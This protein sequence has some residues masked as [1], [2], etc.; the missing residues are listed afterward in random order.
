MIRS[1]QVVGDEAVHAFF[2]CCVPAILDGWP[3]LPV[4]HVVRQIP[5]DPQHVIERLARERGAKALLGT[6][7]A[8]RG[9]KGKLRCADRLNRPGEIV[10][11][12]LRDGDGR[13]GTLLLPD[14]FLSDGVLPQLLGP[15]GTSLFL[16][17]SAQET[18]LLE[19]AGCATYPL[20]AV[21]WANRRAV[22]EFCKSVPWA[23][24]IL[25]PVNDIG[26]GDFTELP[27]AVALLARLRR[28]SHAN[29]SWA[30]RLKFTFVRLHLSQKRDIA[31]LVRG[32]DGALAGYLLRGPVGK[33]RLKPVRLVLPG[34]ILC[35]GLPPL[36]AWHARSG[37]VEP[38]D[39]LGH[40]EI[41]Q[42]SPARDRP[43]RVRLLGEQVPDLA[44]Q[45]RRAV[46]RDTLMDVTNRG[47][48]TYRLDPDFIASTL[49]VPIPELSRHLW[50]FARGSAS[51]PDC[52][53]SAQWSEYLP[54][55][56]A[57]GHLVDPDGPPQ[58][59]AE[60]ELLLVAPPPM[61]APATIRCAAR[62][63][64]HPDSAVRILWCEDI[65]VIPSPGES[66][67]GPKDVLEP[68]L[69]DGQL[70]AMNERLEQLA[71][72]LAA[73]VHQGGQQSELIALLCLLVHGS[74]LQIRLP[75]GRALGCGQL[76]VCILGESGSRKSSVA[77]ELAKLLGLSALATGDTLTRAGLVF[78]ISG[79][80][81]LPGLLSGN[82]AGMLTLDEIHKVGRS[83]IRAATSARSDGVL[84]VHGR[85]SAELPMRTR[86]LG[87]GNLQRQSARGRE[88]KRSLRLADLAAGIEGAGFLECEDA[89]RFD[90][91]LITS[92]SAAT[93]E[94]GSRAQKLD[95]GKLVEL[96]E[97]YW[98]IGASG[99]DE[100]IWETGAFPAVVAAAKALND[101]FECD[102][103]PIFGSDTADK[104]VRLVAAA[105]RVLPVQNDWRTRITTAHVQ[106]VQ[107]LLT[108]IYT[109]PACGLEEVARRERQAEAKPS[110]EELDRI[111]RAVER[112]IA[113]EELDP[114]LEALAERPRLTT[115]ELGGRIDLGVRSTR[116]RVAVL[117]EAGLLRSCGRGGL[118]ALPLMKHLAEYRR[119]LR[120][121]SKEG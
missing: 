117:R 58:A 67:A 28:W 80:E 26:S 120:A 35:N 76:Q 25:V 13:P 42:L 34:N 70:E 21:E 12:V 53:V 44:T 10:A 75:T 16:T 52:P 121:T 88:G 97:G 71:G 83:A 45:P 96:L 47:G 22:R 119:G 78:Q 20:E 50:R 31:E 49:D 46:L 73:A 84:R 85:A 33:D 39:F 32:G 54:M 36:T 99:R 64:L 106:L 93:A 114:I 77:F 66:A 29:P 90:A 18:S 109:S 68:F 69:V 48:G 17:A 89:R 104:I 118:Q 91:V 110:D 5:A 15:R 38:R 37:P 57:R 55:R 98:R 116:A 59:D 9:G 23:R 56:R 95:I 113:P 41:T 61:E 63:L 101:R 74:P 3:D 7:L 111:W 79:N 19:A 103:I 8:Q 30:E 107:T 105:A 87:I 1:T 14:G 102:A 65:E 86:F 112:D 94:R 24:E 2:A 62:V 43:L 92:R 72:G 11:A 27:R 81:V 82:H 60:C 108:D 51:L 100:F 6:G 115:A 4:G 40:F